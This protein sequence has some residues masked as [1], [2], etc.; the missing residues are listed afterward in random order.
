MTAPALRAHEHLVLFDGTCGVCSRA[1]RF[2]MRRDR[3]GVFRFASLQGEP[4][5]AALAR[6][7][8]ADPDPGTFVVVTQW[9]EAPTPLTR[10]RAALFVAA[11]LSWPWR[12]LR[13]LRVLPA[14]ALDGAYDFVARHRH[15]LLRGPKACALPTA[16]ERERCLD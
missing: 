9:R 16:W 3:S 11:H 4:G 2:V 15:R 1:V 5:R 6:A 13:L 10:S 14:A 12:W 7:G 8:V